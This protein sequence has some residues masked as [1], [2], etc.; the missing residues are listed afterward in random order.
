M[1]R[2]DSVSPDETDPE[3]RYQHLVESIQDAVVEFEFVDGEP[4]IRD[5]NDAFVETFGYPLAEIR[6]ES[7]NERIIPKGEYEEARDID[8]RT[9]AGKTTAQ[10]LTRETVTG[11]REFLHRSVPYGDSGDID[12]IAVYTDITER[13][14]AEQKRQLLTE[15]SRCIGESETLRE[16]F[17]TTLEAICDYTEWAYG[18]VWRPDEET[19]QM[20]FSAGHADV[21]ACEE[22]LNRSKDIRFPFGDG[23]PGR[24][25][26]TESPEWLSDISQTKPDMF[27][28][29]DLASDIGLHAAFGTPVIADSKV[30]AVLAFFLRENRPADDALV[31]DVNDIARGLGELVVRKQAEELVKRRNDQL[32]QFA[33]VISHDL[34]NPLNVANSRLEMARTECTSPHLAHVASAHDRIEQLIDDILTLAQQGQSVGSLDVVSLADCAVQGWGMTSTTDAELNV[35]TTTAV[36]GD[37][38]RLQ[39]LFEN[40]L[41]NS[42]EHGSKSTNAETD[43]VTVTVGKTPDGFYIADDGPGIPESE[44]ETVFDAGY[45]T[46]A[47]GTGLGLPIVEEIAEAHGWSVTLSDSETGGARFEFAGVETES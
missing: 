14:R 45:S 20:V 7:L 27:H 4:V 34:R 37:W 31:T 22:F 23:L 21:P 41:H 42:V 29:T 46:Q 35:E 3:V 28:R 1:D 2:S 47:D 11:P 9:A 6:G 18:E 32:E 10:Q 5:A 30:V 43:G 8:D 13:K 33:N 24:V 19:E 15:T 36:R 44:W 17:R 16:G 38:G 25:Y 26:V 39:Q 12:G 40:L